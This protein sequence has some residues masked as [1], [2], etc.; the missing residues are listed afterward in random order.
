[1]PVLATTACP[2]VTGDSDLPALSV[3]A[4]AVA[5]VLLQ[6]LLTPCITAFLPAFKPANTPNLVI[7][8]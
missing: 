1:M 4:P 6:E 7:P 5:Q 3:T 8:D 2:T